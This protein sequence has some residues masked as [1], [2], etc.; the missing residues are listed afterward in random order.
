MAEPIRTQTPQNQ[1]DSSL[2]L[3]DFQIKAI[4]VAMFVV[5][6]P[7]LS[8]QAPDFVKQV[9]SNKMWELF[10]LLLVGVAISYGLLSRKGTDQETEK[11]NANEP[12]N[13]QCFVS[14]MLDGI[15]VFNSGESNNP[16]VQSWSSMYNPNEPLVVVEDEIMDDIAQKT[17]KPLFLPVRSLKAIAQEPELLG[18]D[19][20]FQN[21][22]DGKVS[23][24]TN[25]EEKVDHIKP[26]GN[27][28]S[29]RSMN[30]SFRSSTIKQPGNGR[31]IT[32]QNFRCEQNNSSST[33][34]SVETVRLKSS[35]SMDELIKTLEESESGESFDE[36]ESSN[37]SSCVTDDGTEENEVDKK[38][39]EF[40][41]KFREQIRQQRMQCR[42]IST[43]RKGGGK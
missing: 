39:D 4:F 41:A 14:D 16:D 7:I 9:L 11:G 8:S 6:L 31:K 34:R 38:A 32:A 13:R 28:D 21:D 22:G 30:K 37:S 42:K 2:S 19:G 5:F 29:D 3:S 1:Q 12:D 17:N 33:G 15:P 35:N 24:S 43:V 25:Q 27:S 26:F 40:I 20:L 23:D 18:E 36:E 10:H